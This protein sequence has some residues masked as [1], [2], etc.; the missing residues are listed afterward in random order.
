MVPVQIP[1]LLLHKSLH[2][3]LWG[4]ASGITRGCSGASPFLLNVGVLFRSSSRRALTRVTSSALDA[5]R[6]R[7]PSGAAPRLA[8]RPSRSS[9]LSLD[10]TKISVLSASLRNK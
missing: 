8:V 3:W 7:L 10:M 4:A 9:A 5:N 1:L 2:V 6:E